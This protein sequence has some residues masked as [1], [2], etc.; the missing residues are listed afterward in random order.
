MFSAAW[1]NAAVEYLLTYVYAKHT[2][3]D[4]TKTLTVL[5]EHVCSQNPYYLHS[6]SQKSPYE[7]PDV[8][9]KGF[10]LMNDIDNEE[11]DSNLPGPGSVDGDMQ[12][13]ME[14]LMAFE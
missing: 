14:D 1:R 2:H 7:V 8:F 4:I 12:L 13:E 11:I 6:D 5:I 10:M 9:L 3:P